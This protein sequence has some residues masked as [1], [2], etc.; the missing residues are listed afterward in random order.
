MAFSILTTTV[1]FSLFFVLG[2]KGCHCRFT[3]NWKIKSRSPLTFC[4]VYRTHPLK[5]CVSRVRCQNCSI[6]CTTARVLSPSVTCSKFMLFIRADSSSAVAEML[7]LGEQKAPVWSSPDIWPLDND[8]QISSLPSKEVSHFS[9]RSH[10]ASC[11]RVTEKN[12]KCI[13]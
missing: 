11:G 13:C 9:R 4:N 1:G 10:F 2:M 3:G 7:E 6:Y 8:P 5:T 12:L